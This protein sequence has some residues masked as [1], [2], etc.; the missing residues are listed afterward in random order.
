MNNA[1]E[2]IGSKQR[3]SKLEDSNIEMFQV[4]EKRELRFLKRETTRTIDPLE[5]TT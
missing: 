3:I 1:L 5:E 4:E 2:S